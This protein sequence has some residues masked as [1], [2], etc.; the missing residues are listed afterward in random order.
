VVARLKRLQD[1]GRIS[2]N[3][4]HDQEFYRHET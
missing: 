2:H 4:Y 1:S 3:R